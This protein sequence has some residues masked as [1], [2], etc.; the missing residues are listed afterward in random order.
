MDASVITVVAL[1][2]VL[3]NAALVFILNRRQVANLQPLTARFDALDG[4]QD[5]TERRVREEIAG[6]RREAGEHAQQLRLE[7]GAAV[8][9]ASDTLLQQLVE[10]AKVRDE[11]LQ[12][13]RTALTAGLVAVKDELTVQGCQM[14]EELSG[15]LKGFADTMAQRFDAFD[16]RLIEGGRER[17][18]KLEKVRDTLDAGLAH[19]RTQ[20]GEHLLRMKDDAQTSAKALG[21][22][23]AQNLNQFS[24]TQ[25][26]NFDDLITRIGRMVEP[27]RGRGAGA[28][29]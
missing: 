28:P 23:M 7:V 24:A 27:R 15:A 6:N 16:A 18:A 25:R 10:G 4:A 5:R 29:P 11:K 21:E 9:S 19:S 17:D 3:I 20:I 26:T 8:K 13:V 1:I 14:R 12:A 2:S 22:G